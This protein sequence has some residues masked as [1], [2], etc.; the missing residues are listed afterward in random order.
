MV[1][2]KFVLEDGTAI[3]DDVFEFLPPMTILIGKTGDEG[4]PATPATS[5]HGSLQNDSE[6][7]DLQPSSGQTTSP[8]ATSVDNVDVVVREQTPSRNSLASASTSS[9]EHSSVSLPTSTQNTA[10]SSQTRATN[11]NSPRNADILIG[12]F[13]VII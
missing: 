3:D 6:E 2:D 8:G 10:P 12:M 4:L 5:F 1:I 7:L 13:H 11:G 9:T